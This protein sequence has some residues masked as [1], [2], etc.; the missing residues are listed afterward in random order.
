MIGGAG[1]PDALVERVY[2]ALI[3]QWRYCWMRVVR[4][5]ARPC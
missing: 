2:K 3:A 5:P 4:K 1:A